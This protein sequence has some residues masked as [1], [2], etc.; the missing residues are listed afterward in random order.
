MWW[1]LEYSSVSRAFNTNQR[2]PVS[3]M[4]SITFLAVRWLQ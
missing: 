2:H 3:I 4:F 1:E